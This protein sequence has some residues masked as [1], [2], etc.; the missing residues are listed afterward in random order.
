MQLVR[1]SAGALM[2]R[3]LAEVR[4]YEIPFGLTEDRRWERDLA[5]LV[6][7]G[8]DLVTDQGTF[9]VTWTAQEAVGYRIDCTPGPLLDRRL[10]RVQV[11]HVED[12]EPWSSSV[13]SV[14]ETVAVHESFSSS[15]G[16]Q[17]VRF[18]LALTI[19]FTTGQTIC[20]V[21]GSWHGVD[22]AIFPTGNDI[23]IIWKRESVPILLPFLA[24]EIQL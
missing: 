17:W 18:P 19:K 24:G 6:D 12:A 23:V 22:K 8:L 4:Y 2:G 9:A 5:H 15:F 21:F 20:L 7:Y 1:K 16:E 3:K 14:V 10:D 11:S 13:G